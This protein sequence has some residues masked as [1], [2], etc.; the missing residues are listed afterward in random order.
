MEKFLLTIRRNRL[1]LQYAHFYPIDKLDTYLPDV[2]V[3]L[4]GAYNMR[5]LIFNTYTALREQLHSLFQSPNDNA[6]DYKIQPYH[7]V[8]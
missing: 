7:I 6:S 5:L 1:S 3:R 4:V 8:Q 2:K